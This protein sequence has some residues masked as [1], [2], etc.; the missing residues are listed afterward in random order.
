MARGCDDDNNYK[1]KD[2]EVAC[3][4]WLRSPGYR[5][6]DAVC[7]DDRGYVYTHGYYVDFDDIGVRPALYINLNP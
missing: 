4:W 6:I 1:T 3:Y 5:A 7:V 2:G